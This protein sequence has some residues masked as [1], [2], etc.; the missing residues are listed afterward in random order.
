MQDSELYV[1]FNGKVY[2]FDVSCFDVSCFDVFK[3]NCIFVSG[4]LTSL[5][6]SIE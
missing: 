2:I 1:T 3:K 6:Y 5:A 4:Y